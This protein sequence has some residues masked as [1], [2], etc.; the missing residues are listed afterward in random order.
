M[1][2]WKNK[3]NF[4]YF[5]LQHFQSVWGPNQSVPG[6]IQCN[7]RY[8]PRRE[9][10]WNHSK[11][12]HLFIVFRGTMHNLGSLESKRSRTSRRK[13]C[14]FV[15][16]SA[17]TPSNHSSFFISYEMKVFFLFFHTNFLFQELS[18]NYPEI[19]TL[20]FSLQSRK[21][22]IGIAQSFE[23][24]NLGKR[25]KRKFFFQFHSIVLGEMW[26]KQTQ[27]D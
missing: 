22:K 1:H 27:Y 16:L 21:I 24:P 5:V 20:S 3:I 25:K 17:I 23:S 11:H 14:S 7:Y 10:L 19:P 26:S 18:G 13:K 15:S 12:F 4:I 8:Q 9:Q 6:A 2:T